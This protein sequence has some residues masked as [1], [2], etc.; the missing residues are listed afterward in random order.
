MTDAVHI[1]R[2]H[3]GSD[4]VWSEVRESSI[5]TIMA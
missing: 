5:L 4:L 3:C 2:V 1:Q